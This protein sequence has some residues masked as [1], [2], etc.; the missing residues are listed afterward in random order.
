MLFSKTPLFSPAPLPFF[1]PRKAKIE[2]R[3]VDAEMQISIRE[4][5]TGSQSNTD[6]TSAYIVLF[7]VKI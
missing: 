6:V 2:F 1:K 5:L 4:G 7:K 3:Q